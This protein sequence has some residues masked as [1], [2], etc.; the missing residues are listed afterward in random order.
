[1]FFQEGRTQVKN[2][3]KWINQNKDEW[4]YKNLPLPKTKYFKKAL[5][6]HDWEDSDAGFYRWIA[7]ESE[8]MSSPSHFY[9]KEFQAIWSGKAE[10]YA[11][12]MDINIWEKHRKFYKNLCLY[13]M[14]M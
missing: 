10:N 2:D 14:I 9:F 1:M 13:S 12:K 7:I 3:F 6:K 8:H 5:K 11:Q 4:D